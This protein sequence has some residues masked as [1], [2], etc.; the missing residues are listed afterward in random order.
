MEQTKALNALEPFIAL[1]KSATS[2][3]AA[4]DLIERA[5]SAPNTYI[6]T[7]LLQSP[8]IQTVAASHPELQ[9]HLTL[10]RIFSYGD[11]E[12]Y[13]STPDL[14][15]LSDAQR[16]KLRQLSLLSLAA[17][18]RRENLTYGQLRQRLRLDSTRQLE[19]LVTTAIYAGLVDAKLDPAR[20][21]VQ[22]A[23]VA[24][25]R[26]LSPDDVAQMRAAL[27]GWSDRCSS[28]LE[29]VEAH[30][31][32]V[33]AAAAARVKAESEA[34]DKLNKAMAEL[35]NTDKKM[36]GGGGGGSMAREQLARRGMNKRLMPDAATKANTDEA[37]DLDGP[38]VG[39]DGK[40]RA[41][42]RKM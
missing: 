19:T 13:E 27:R 10:L 17:S 23:S 1:S 2:P 18:G 26:D 35:Q 15:P 14:P 3:R 28:V 37:M 20:Q 31:A 29:D 9:P 40:K 39:E 30:M 7:E 5:T 4:A 34:T 22:V 42:K 6:F 25:L 21:R 24:P 16:L 41:S 11:Y 12:T 36:G 8:Q 33:R 38:F 32:Q